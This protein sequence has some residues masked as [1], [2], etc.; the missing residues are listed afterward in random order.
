MFFVIIVIVIT[1]ITKCSTL[2][3]AAVFFV[4]CFVSNNLGYIIMIISYSWI[5]AG[6]TTR[7]I[8]FLNSVA[9]INLYS[10][11]FKLFSSILHSCRLKAIFERT[12]VFSWILLNSVAVLFFFDSK[13]SFLNISALLP[14]CVNILGHHPLSRLEFFIWL[15]MVTC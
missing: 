9:L 10:S 4:Q 14:F 13:T 12:R 7:N 1:I 15:S 2:D 3:V 11:C 6:S 5:T 8:K